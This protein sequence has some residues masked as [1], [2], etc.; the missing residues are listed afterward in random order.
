MENKAYTYLFNDI[1]GKVLELSENPSQFA[2]YLSQQIRELVGARTIIIAVKTEAGHP[3]IFSVF[4]TRRSEWAHQND[5]YQLADLSFGFETIQY[6]D[7]E[8]E[9]GNQPDY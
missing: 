8:S 1:L 9:S 5:I 6:L 4:P 2:E 7:V 3:K